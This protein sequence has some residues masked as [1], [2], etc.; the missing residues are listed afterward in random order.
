MLRIR[1]TKRLVI[2][3][4][5]HSHLKFP[6]Q[7]FR[8]KSF[9]HAGMI[10][11]DRGSYKDLFSAQDTELHFMHATLEDFDFRCVFRADIFNETHTNAVR[12]DLNRAIP[13]SNTI[14]CR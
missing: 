1:R 13:V 7:F 4:M 9:G 6:T 2:I 8:I 5:H 14:H 12:F 11:I 3:V 10:I